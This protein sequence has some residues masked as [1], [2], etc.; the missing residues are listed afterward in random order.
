MKTFRP[1][2]DKPKQHPEKPCA[3]AGSRLACKTV[4]LCRL[5]IF[6]IFVGW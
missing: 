2:K 6:V 5:G 4:S 1:E 3:S